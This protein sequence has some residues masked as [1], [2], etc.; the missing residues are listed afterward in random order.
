MILYHFV[1]WAD[2]HNRLCRMI[3]NSEGDVSFLLHKKR[4]IEAELS[5]HADKWLG[6]TLPFAPLNDSPPR[7]GVPHSI[8]AL[9]PPVAAQDLAFIPDSDLLIPE[10]MNDTFIP[11]SIH[12][13]G[14]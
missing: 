9:E 2:E 3:K 14:L 5:K 1:K 13:A 8:P 12:E 4:Q 7:I 10:S 6:A 11:D